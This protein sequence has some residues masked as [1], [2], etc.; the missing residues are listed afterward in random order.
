MNELPESDRPAARRPVRFVTLILGVLISTIG[1]WLIVRAANP[2]RLGAA[3]STIVPGWI[4]VGLGA[5]VLTFFTRTWRWAGLLQPLKLPTSSIMAALLSG[6]VL[7]F[8]LPLR[9]G[10]VVR[11][12]MLGRHPNSSTAR[13][14]GSVVIEKGWDWLMLCLIVVVATV[15]APLP[16]WFST[17]A[18]TVGLIAVLIL[19][20]FGLIAVAPDHW[21]SRIS[22]LTDRW[23]GWLPARVLNSGQRLMESLTALRHREALVSATVGSLATWVLGVVANYAVL[24]AFGVVSLSAALILIVVLM[25]GVALPPSIAAIGVFEGLTILTLNAFD[26]S[27][28]TGL[29]IGITLHSVIFVPPVL[30]AALLWWAART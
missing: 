21:S 24:R 30:A 20:A 19:V 12:I 15:I 3:F 26:V 25:V 4:V 9:L 18:R 28:E 1:V 8:L 11:S 5:I 29:A 22:T 17:P 14:F 16:D 10:D 6:Q 23:F 7:N 2:D 27:I 13:V